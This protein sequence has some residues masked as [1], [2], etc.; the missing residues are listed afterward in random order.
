MKRI[1]LFL[2]LVA[3]CGFGLSCSDEGY[4]KVFKCNAA[5]PYFNVVDNH[6]YVDEAAAA[7]ANDRADQDADSASGAKDNGG[8][9]EENSDSEASANQDSEKGSQ[10]SETDASPD[11]DKE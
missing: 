7:A 5:Y 4:I 6:C 8:M 3:V 2:L 9:T 11:S 10:G 1:V